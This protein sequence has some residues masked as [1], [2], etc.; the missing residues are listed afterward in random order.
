MGDA[1]S[2]NDGVTTETFEFVLKGLTA[3]AGDIPIY[4]T[5]LETASQIASLVN[6]AI[7]AATSSSFTTYSA[8]NGTTN[9]TT[10]LPSNRV[11]LFNVQLASANA[12]LEADTVAWETAQAG[13]GSVAAGD[14]SKN[15][16]LQFSNGSFVD[17]PVGG[18]GEPSGLSAIPGDVDVRPAIGETIIDAAQISDSLD[19]GI[20]VKPGARAAGSEASSPGS[21]SPLSID[22]NPLDA[23]NASL[24]QVGGVTLENNVISQFGDGGI[25]LLGDPDPA[26]EPTAAVSFFRVVNNTIYGGTDYE[27]PR[28]STWRGIPHPR[29]S[30]T[31]SP[32]STTR[33]RWT[34]LRRVDRLGLHGLP[35]HRRFGD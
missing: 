12:G 28:A 30:T 9:L 18:D 33:L 6:A 4:Y 22:N 1:F 34:P 29:F 19:W 2:L 10:T 17:L 31:S 5:G 11:D 7:N 15:F 3:R 8:W 35:E 13:T 23:A 21:V 24:D 27:R 14:S 25:D 32:T 20:V 16:V 26:G